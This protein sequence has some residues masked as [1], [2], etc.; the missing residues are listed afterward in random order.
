MSEARQR[1]LDYIKGYNK[2]NY[3][4]VRVQV[5]KKTETELLDY[6]NTK[7]NKSGYIK[8]LITKDMKK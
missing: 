7:S 5:N 4:V 2:D 3:V 1:Q 8:E 6:L